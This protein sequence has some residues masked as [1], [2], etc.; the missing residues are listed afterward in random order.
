MSGIHTSISTLAATAQP[1]STEIPAPLIPLLSS[2]TS[3]IYTIE[4]LFNKVPGSPIIVRYIKS[5]YQDDPWRSVLELFLLAFAIRTVLKGRTRGEGEG[6]SFIK[7]T[8]KEIDELVDDFNPLPLA[9]DPTPADS[10]T[11]DTVPTIYG[12]NGIKVKTSANGKTLLNLATPNWCGFIENDKMKQVAI[13]TLG[14]Y[15]VGTC[16]PSGF[17]GTIDVHQKA[18]ADIASFIGTEA[19]IIY[20]QAFALVSSA[21]PAFAKRG[22]IIVADRGVNFGIHK[23]LQISR[24][25]IKW[26]AHGD[27]KDL[28]RVLQSVERDRK[29]KGGKLTKKFIVAEGIFENDGMLLDLPKVI[30][31]KKKYKYRLILDECQSF[32]MMGAHGRGITEHFGVPANEVDM[33]LGSLA[34]G[35]ATGGGFC[36]GSQVVCQH[37]RINSS[38]SVFSASL[39]A[40]LATCGSA[41]IDI[42]KAQPNLMTSLQSNIALFRQQLSKLEGDSK[43]ALISIPSDPNSGL[44]HI[45]LLNP[46]DSLEEEE[47]I[48]Q[49]IVDEC[50][51]TSNLLITRARRLR[52]QEVFEPEPSLKI[53]ISGYMARKDVEA[54][55][56]GL[57]A[58]IVKVCGN[59]VNKVDADCWFASWVD[60]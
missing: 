16:G 40:M 18:E 1:A 17:Y 25:N 10:F 5:S 48:L 3:L 45:F 57:K 12:P 37:Q 55:G 11:L 52:S 27:M 19:S 34:N 26:Y 49:E 54:A 51:Q 28:E 6:K 43:D 30:E 36:A 39:P 58:A 47:L 44:I 15:G 60:Y 9:D 50:Q 13:E 23:G 41:A 59:I 4:H 35:L 42:L 56:R 24:S 46:P 29:R 31:L 14:Q 20:S 32:G 2:L 53:C 22:D 21:I 8:E 38:A 33:I 7:L